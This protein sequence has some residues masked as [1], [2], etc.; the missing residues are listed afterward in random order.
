MHTHTPGLYNVLND[1]DFVI[2]RYSV[3][4]ATVM[5]LWRVGLLS[6]FDLLFVFYRVANILKSSVP[7]VKTQQQHGK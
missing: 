2:Q 6:S 3:N 5:R 4:S 1:I 7:K